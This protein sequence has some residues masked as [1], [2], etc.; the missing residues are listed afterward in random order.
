MNITKKL[1]TQCDIIDQKLNK[2]NKLYAFC[3]GFKCGDCDGEFYDL[4]KTEYD[5]SDLLT[6]FPSF[7]IPDTDISDEVF[8][9]KPTITK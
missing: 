8:Y 4:W 5:H 9:S 6:K 1:I 7:V 3:V 2:H